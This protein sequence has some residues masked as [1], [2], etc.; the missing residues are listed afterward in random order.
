MQSRHLVNVENCL[1]RQ[2]CWIQTITQCNILF[3]LVRDL[4]DAIY[5]LKICVLSISD[6]TIIEIVIEIAILT[7]NRTE[8]KS[9][10]SCT[11]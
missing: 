4:K 8:S 11:P 6:V 7:E 5:F 10:I 2:H 9:R 1:Q 3:L